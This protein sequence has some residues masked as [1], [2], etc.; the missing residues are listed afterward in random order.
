MIQSAFSIGIDK[1]RNPFKSHHFHVSGSIILLLYVLTLSTMM[2]YAVGGYNAVSMQCKVNSSLGALYL[3]TFI[4]T[5]LCT[6]TQ[7][8][9]V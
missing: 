6:N 2:N 9:P 5:G 1:M 3:V 7:Q 4:P 8:S